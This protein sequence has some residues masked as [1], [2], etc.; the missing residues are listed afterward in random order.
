MPFK[1]LHL[2]FTGDIAMITLSRPEKRNAISPEMIVEL[3]SAFD[4]VEASPARQRGGL[5][6]SATCANRCLFFIAD[7]ILWATV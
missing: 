2:E 4:E 6:N 1:A 3:L 7:E 5:S